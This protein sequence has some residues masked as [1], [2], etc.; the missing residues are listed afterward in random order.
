[1]VAIS[2]SRAV[3]KAG[4]ALAVLGHLAAIVLYI[5]LPSLEVPRPVL[6]AFAAAWLVVAAVILRLLSSRPW[7][8]VGVALVGSVLA[9]V[10]RILGEQHLGWRG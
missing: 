1:M 8:G 7:I 4:A 9:G 3:A 5:I 2:E 10:I 6:F